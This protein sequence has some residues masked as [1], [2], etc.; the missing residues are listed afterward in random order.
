LALA[1][2]HWGT[3]FRTISEDEAQAVLEAAWHGGVRHFDTA[4]LYGMGLSE[5]RINRFLRG[6]LRGECVISTKVG[7]LSLAVPPGQGDGPGI[8]VGVPSRRERGDYSHD[9]VLRSIEESLEWLGLEW[10]DIL[11][12]R[13]TSTSSIT[14]PR[15]RCRR[16]WKSSWPVATAPFSACATKA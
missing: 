1:L 9:G 15:P 4:P 13:M 8:G 16:G 14:G 3:F 5:T 6:K 7:R 12:L 11:L 2:R 10:V